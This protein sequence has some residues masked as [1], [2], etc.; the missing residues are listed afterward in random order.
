MELVSEPLGQENLTEVF[1]FVRT[2]N[3]FAQ[4]TWGWDTGRF[5]DWRWGSSPAFEAVA[6]G[7]MSRHCTIYRTGGVTAAVSIAEYGG[8]SEI[9]ITTSPL[10]EVVEA[11]L[12]SLLADHRTRKIALVFEFSDR[13]EWLRALCRAAGLS[14]EKGAGHEWEYDL[15]TVT[16]P[17]SLPDGF[18]L[19]SLAG[20]TAPPLAAVAECIRMAFEST[21]DIETSLR[22]LQANPMYRPELSALVQAP[23]GRVAAY[24]RG[25]VDP[26]NGVCGID[27]VCTHPE[28]SRRGFGKAVVQACLATQRSLGGRFSYIGSA[29]EP[30]PGTFLYRSLGPTDRIDTCRWTIS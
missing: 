30:A 9:V 17:G 14:E 24:C 10:P 15:A 29:A 25:T 16:A 23:D 20:K 27:P 19:D 18:V 2:A 5:V 6:P 21:N 13:A 4:H 7:W 26:V 12:A 8:E 28:F 22:S 3:P 1:R 11:I